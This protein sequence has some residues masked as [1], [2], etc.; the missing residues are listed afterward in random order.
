MTEVGDVMIVLVK[1]IGACRRGAGRGGYFSLFL[2]ID[3][4]IQFGLYFGFIAVS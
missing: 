3:R 4:L 1:A 2:D